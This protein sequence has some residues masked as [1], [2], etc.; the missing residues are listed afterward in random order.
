M[1]AGSLASAEAALTILRRFVA[2]ARKLGWK[3]DD[4]MV[5]GILEAVDESAAAEILGRRKHLHPLVVLPVTEQH[6]GLLPSD[7]EW[8]VVFT[9]GTTIPGGFVDMDIVPVVVGEQIRINGDD[10]MKQADDEQCSFGLGDA[11]VLHER[12]DEIPSRLYKCSFIFPRTVLMSGK[13]RYVVSLVRDRK[14]GDWK[15]VPRRLSGWFYVN[16][17]LLRPRKPQELPRLQLT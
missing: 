16:D 2:A 7:R 3:E 9:V 14:T 11:A 5:Q 1:K 6:L 17:R 15:I 8:G 12:Q 13:E 10:L 4:E